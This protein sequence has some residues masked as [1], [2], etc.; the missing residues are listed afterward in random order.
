V[1]FFHVVFYSTTKVF[2]ARTTINARLNIIVKSIDFRKVAAKII[3]KDF[4]KVG[5]VPVFS[6]RTV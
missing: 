5:T 4:N 2:V 6:R 3:F 1:D